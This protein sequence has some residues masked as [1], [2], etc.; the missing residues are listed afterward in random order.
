MTRKVYDKSYQKGLTL[1]Q[2]TDLFFDEADAKAWIVGQRWPD[3][4]ICPY[5]GTP[6]VQSNIKHKTMMYR[7]REC[8]NKVMFS[9][10]TGTV[11]ES[12]NLKYRVWAV[13]MYLF[14]TNLKGISSMRLHRELGVGQKAAWF[15]LHRL[16]KVFDVH[17][18]L[19]SGTVEVDETYIDS[20]DA[21]K[22]VNKKT[23][24]GNNYGVKQPVVGMKSRDTNHV[25]AEV[26]QTVSAKAL[27]QFVKTNTK[28][29][30]TVDSD[31]HRGYCGL[32][33]Q[34]Y[35][36][37]QVNHSGKE[38]VNGPAHTSGIELFGEG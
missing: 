18:S 27:Q 7:C 3:G 15:M 1:L 35:D 9:L 28:P 33:K 21:N 25:K 31:Q 30:G 29:S 22:H 11:M 24:N 37:E 19:F 36:S 13:A 20:I 38:Y 12:S 5:C 4:P 26:L 32:R 34:G 23:Q 10:K 6:N 2:I 17:T 8:P 16:R 14:A